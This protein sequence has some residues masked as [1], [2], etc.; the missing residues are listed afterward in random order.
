VMST[1]AFGS[2]PRVVLMVERIRI[3]DPVAAR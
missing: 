2:E 1:P 3:G